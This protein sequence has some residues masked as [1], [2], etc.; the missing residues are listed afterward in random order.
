MSKRTDA[1]RYADVYPVPG[2]S[3]A[4]SSATLQAR[5]GPV[6]P[7]KPGFNACL[8]L[9]AFMHNCSNKFLPAICNA[10]ALT[11]NVLVARLIQLLSHDKVYIIFSLK[12]I[13]LKEDK[14]VSLVFKKCRAA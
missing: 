6:R 8:C 12:T 14:L 1:E 5:Y 7:L 11:R 3:F 4:Q 2:L 10:A 9:D 13:I